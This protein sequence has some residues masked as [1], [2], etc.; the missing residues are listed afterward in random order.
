MSVLPTKT[1]EEII[2][3]EQHWPLWTQNAAAL[4]LAPASVLAVKTAT[5]NARK[6]FD[7]AQTARLASKD[8]T[9]GM[10]NN[11]ATMHNLASD[12]IQ[13]IRLYAESTNNPNVFALGGIPIPALPTAALPPTQPI[14]LR[15]SIEPS[16][17]LTLAWKAGPAPTSPVNGQMF[18]AS[19]S[20]VQYVIKRK[21]NNETTYTQIGTADPSRGGARGTSAFT[22]ETLLAG[23]TNIQYIITGKRGALVGPMSEVLNIVVGI[24]GGGGLFI[25]STS[26]TPMKMAA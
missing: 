4:S 13:S 10:K 19:T 8:A 26:S 15:A 2:F 21:V 16:G 18:D 5:I 6:A 3:C 17:A 12:V 14:Q 25:Q 9:T 24:G 20:G 23:S 11:V 22:D 1:I 7:D